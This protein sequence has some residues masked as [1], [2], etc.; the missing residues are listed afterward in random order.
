MDLDPISQTYE[1]VIKLA[2]I[3]GEHQVL[4]KD[5]HPKQLDRHPYT[6]LVGDLMEWKHRK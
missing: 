4:T 3:L 2:Q 1:D 5:S 6:N